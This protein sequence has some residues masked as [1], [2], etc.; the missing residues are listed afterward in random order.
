MCP[1]HEWSKCQT[2]L[3]SYM[4]IGEGLAFSVSCSLSTRLV[5]VTNKCSFIHRP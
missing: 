4:V 1:L 5:S 2:E 3:S